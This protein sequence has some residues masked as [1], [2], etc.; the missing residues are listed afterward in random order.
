MSARR[1]AAA[2]RAG[3]GAPPEPE[4]PAGRVGPNA[5]TRVDQAL[6]ALF[7]AATRDR[8]FAEAGLL[9]HVRRPPEAMVDEDDVARLT[10]AVR[11][12]LGPRDAD[13]IGREA[14]R[15]T[16]D[17]LLA[18][19]IPTAARL[20]LRALPAPLAARLFARAIARHAWTFAGSGRFGHRWRDGGLDLRIDDS[21]VCRLVDDGH[22]AC[23]YSAATFAGLFGAVLGRPVRVEETACRAAGDPSCRFRVTW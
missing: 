19:R 11:V 14:G 12:T 9:H 16:A 22:R 1:T 7:D 4:R 17:Y 10:R 8:V 6:V 15:T 20:L 5:V 3:A 21:P 23:S 2:D 13:R 18:R